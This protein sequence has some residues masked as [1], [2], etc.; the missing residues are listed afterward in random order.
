VKDLIIFVKSIIKVSLKLV[1]CFQCK[2][3]TSSA[4]SGLSQPLTVYYFTGLVIMCC[5]NTL[6][7]SMKSELK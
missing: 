7:V 4:L 2:D 1:A 6:W 3:F 5:Q